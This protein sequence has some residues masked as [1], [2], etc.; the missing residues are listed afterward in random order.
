MQVTGVEPNLAQVITSTKW[1]QGSSA[2]FRQLGADGAFVDDTY[3]KNHHLTVGSPISLLTPTGKTL[4]SAG[5]GDLQ[6]AH[7][8]LAVRRR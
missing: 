1:K 3:A 7:R 6:P 4:D 8:G 2:V 5:E